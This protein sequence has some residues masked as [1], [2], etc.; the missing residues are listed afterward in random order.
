MSRLALVGAAVL[1]GLATT[2]AKQPSMRSL[3][4]QHCWFELREAIKGRNVPPLYKG[5]VASAFNEKR[6]AVTYLNQA[7]KEKPDS[8]IAIDAHEALADL[9]IRLGKY[10]QVVEQLDEILKIKSGRQDVEN[11]RI[12]YAAWSRHPDLLVQKGRPDSFLADV[13]K[14]GVRLPVHIHGKTV[15]WLLDTDNN[16]SVMS[17]SEAQM[18]GVKVDESS[19]DLGDSAGG[20]TKAHTAFLDQLTIANVQVT[21][22]GFVVLPDSREPM[23]GWKPSYK[24]IIGLPVI[25][26]LQSIAWKSDG[27]FEI[28]A[29][30]D[31]SPG[32]SRNLAFDDLSPITRVRCGDKGL[33]FILDTGNQGGTQLWTRFAKDFPALVK[34]SGSTAR[35]QV[36][37]FGG[38]TMREITELPEVQLQVGGLKAT[39]QP[40]RIFSK[41]I[42]DD[43]H[44][45]LLGMDVLGQAREV[46]IDFRSMTL[47]LLR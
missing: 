19:A 32:A 10:H 27:T 22:V 20:A 30:P 45:G 7:I 42:G 21:N 41:P 6:L 43:L 29:S 23:S 31:V 28:G 35:H 26:A 44:A 34:R 4:D 25:I 33:D 37:E 15:H 40:A 3:Y 24:G 13:T 5:T 2:M 17:E 39:L 47:K 18:L 11:A 38:S 16:V 9:Y 12:V 46:R 36:T 14:D 8:D 1:V